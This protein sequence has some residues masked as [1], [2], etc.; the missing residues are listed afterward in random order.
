MKVKIIL[1]ALLFSATTFS[2]VS[3]GDALP[4]PSANLDV[5]AIDVEGNT[6]GLLIPRLNLLNTTDASTINNGNVNSLLVFNEAT[7]ADVT[8]GFYYWYIDKWER[9]SNGSG[10]VTETNTDL[11]FNPLTSELFYVNEFNNN[12]PIDLNSLKIEPWQVEGTADKA[13]LNTQNI[14]QIGNVGIGTNDMLDGVALDVRGAVRAGA[15]NTGVVGLNSVTFGTNNTVSGSNSSATGVN[16]VV[17][18]SISGAIGENNTINSNNAMAIGIGNVVNATKSFTVGEANVVTGNLASAMGRENIADGEI[19]VAYGLNNQSIADYSYTLGVGNIAGAMGSMVF[20]RY[21][22]LI[23]G[24][25]T[26][27]SV[28]LDPYF[29]LGNGSGP[30]NRSNM[31]TILKNGKIGFGNI[32]TPQATIHVVKTGADLTPA[33]IEGCE[34]YP[35]NVAATAA[36]VPVGGLY[37][38]ATGVLMVRF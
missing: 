25:P 19:A 8:P 2:Q 34:V 9:I 31:I 20:G 16:N 36:G 6:R 5:T 15:G 22:A 18:G 27:F 26:N 1:A 3:I 10:S 4:N 35:D 24:D 7:Q 29:Q 14:Y 11:S 13:S 30:A 28:P 12:A 37:R 38:T 33:I 17:L 21:N 23:G 32:Y